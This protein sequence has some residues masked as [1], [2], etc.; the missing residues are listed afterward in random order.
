MISE[1]EIIKKTRNMIPKDSYIDSEPG[2]VKKHVPHLVN[3]QYGCMLGS[4]GLNSV[5][6][7]QSTDMVITETAV[8]IKSNITPID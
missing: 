1:V 2:S 3:T 6:K 5:M 4:D 8:K 7:N